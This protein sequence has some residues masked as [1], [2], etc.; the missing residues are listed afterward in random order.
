MSVQE[1]NNSLRSSGV[2]HACPWVPALVDDVAAPTAARAAAAAPPPRRPAATATP[3]SEV[4][5]AALAG[6]EEPS[7]LGV[8]EDRNEGA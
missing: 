4:P 1:H 2:N 6:N 8:P 5:A 7:A 3:R